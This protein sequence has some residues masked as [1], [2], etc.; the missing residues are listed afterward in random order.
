MGAANF[1]STFVV[2]SDSDANLVW[3]RY[4]E[5][6]S[7]YP[8]SSVKQTSDG[9][10]VLAGHTAILDDTGDWSLMKVDAEGLLQWQYHYPFDHCSEC[11]CIE[12]ASDGGLVLG[13]I[14]D[15]NFRLLKTDREGIFQ[16]TREYDGGCYEECYSVKSTDD[17]GFLLF[18]VNWYCG[19]AFVVKADGNGDSLW[20]V[21]MVDSSDAI[22]AGTSG[23]AVGGEGFLLFGNLQQNGEMDYWVSFSS[24]NLSELESSSRPVIITCLRGY[25]NPFN[26]VSNIEFMLERASQIELSVYDVLGRLIVTPLSGNL[27]SGKYR[28][29]INASAWSSGIYF[30]RLQSPNETQI[31][32]IIVEK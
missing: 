29:P 5:R 27:P 30:C 24:T 26:S 7:E 6:E 25:P 12:E 16:W 1:D 4:Y 10:F 32:K 18:G 2:R 17:D 19:T 21:Q 3:L 31:Q 13:G 20:S 28:V 23:I 14:G 9:G 8:L 22:I 11:T 15:G